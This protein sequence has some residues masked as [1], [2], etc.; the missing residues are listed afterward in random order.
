MKR[1]FVW[2]GLLWIAIQLPFASGAFR[3]DE[4][5]HLKAAEHLQRS[6]A[7]PYGFYVNWNGTPEWAFRTYASPP[8][9]PEW[10]A[11]WSLFPGLNFLFAPACCHFR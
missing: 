11:L 1:Q 6:P 8:L 5:Y 2:A 4:P 10:L 9:V 3:I 7:D